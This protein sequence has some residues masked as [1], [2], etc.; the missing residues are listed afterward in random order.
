MI[1]LENKKWKIEQCFH[2]KTSFWFT[3]KKL[4]PEN[5]MWQTQWCHESTLFNLTWPKCNTQ[6]QHGLSWKKADFSISNMIKISGT[7][8]LQFVHAYKYTSN[9]K[10]KGVNTFLIFFNILL[11][12]SPTI[13]IFQKIFSTKRDTPSFCHF[14]YQF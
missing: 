10:L 2:Y 3:D 13:S 6:L 8:I 1:A 14:L 4:F 11:R 5:V 9:F 7:G 12:K